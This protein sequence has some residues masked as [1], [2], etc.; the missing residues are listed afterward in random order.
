MICQ[1]SY[2]A[3]NTFLGTKGNLEKTIV[4]GALV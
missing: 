2:S 4:F 3:I 1:E